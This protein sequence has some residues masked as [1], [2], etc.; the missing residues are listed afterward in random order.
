M[1]KN[2]RSLKQ[3]IPWRPTSLLSVQCCYSHKNYLLKEDHQKECNQLIPNAKIFLHSLWKMN[4]IEKEHSPIL[5]SSFSR[6]LSMSASPPLLPSQTT[7][8]WLRIWSTLIITRSLVNDNIMKENNHL[9]DTHFLSLILGAWLTDNYYYPRPF[10]CTN[11]KKLYGF[12]KLAESTSKKV[13]Y[14]L[15]EYGSDSDYS[16]ERLL[17]STLC[18]SREFWNHYPY[19][20]LNASNQKM[21]KENIKEITQ[22]NGFDWKW[23]SSRDNFSHFTYSL[24]SVSQDSRIASTDRFFFLSK[25]FPKTYRSLLMWVNMRTNNR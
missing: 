17:V 22:I 13:E 19:S 3:F 24:I 6:L 18:F 25:L 21:R 9:L 16:S 7:F 8:M 14:P 4:W 11:A 20:S 12:V 2:S 23:L 10:L 15:N 1:V 5:S